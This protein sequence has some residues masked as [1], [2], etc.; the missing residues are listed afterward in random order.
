[1][2][3]KTKRMSNSIALLIAIVSCVCVGILFLVS[4]E[5]M[6]E[7]M[8][9][10]A[11]NNIMTSLNAKTQ[12]IDEYI[13]NAETTL[14]VFAKSGELIE[15]A[16]DPSNVSKQEAAQR[17]TNE[18][19]ATIDN[20]EGIYLASW[21]SQVITHPAPPVVG[22]VMREGDALKDL[23]DSMLNAPDKMYNTGIMASPASGELIISMYTPVYDGDTVV[24]YVGGAVLASGLKELLDASQIESLPNAEYSLI[25]IH[26]GVYIFDKDETL[27]NT[28]VKDSFLLDMMANAKNGIMTD[29]MEY[30][31]DGQGYF[32]VY[33]V[34]EDRE[35][36][37]VIRDTNSEIFSLV[38]SGRIALGILCLIAVMLIALLA[39]AVISMKTKPLTIAVD[40]IT[41]LK[42]LNLNENK[43]IKKYTGK[44]D[45]I[46]S[47]ANAVESLTHTLG[48]IVNTMGKCSESLTASADIMNKSSKELMERIETDA[49]TTQ[50]LSAG[51]I[52]TNEAISQV[53]TEIVNMQEL[54]NHIKQ[55]VKDGNVNSGK[56][57]ESSSE[58]T[59]AANTAAQNSTSKIAKTKIH[60]DEAV[61]NLQALNRINDM[62][63]QILEITTQTNLLSL[64]ASIEAARAGEAGRGFAVV[65]DEIAKLAN[66]SS[67]TVSQIQSLCEEANESIGQ[68]KDCF[69]DIVQFLETDVF[70]QFTEFANVSEQYSGVVADIK[71]SIDTI[72][73]STAAFIGSVETITEQVKSVGT[74]SSDNERGVEELIHNN[75]ETTQTV[76]EV[77]K[78]AEENTNNA[79]TLQ[80]IIDKFTQ[81]DSVK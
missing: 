19:F 22:K 63:A 59:H 43:S 50:E 6:T 38:Y 1:M 10:S 16:C 20:W 29:T 46:G 25:N 31:A 65:A 14:A 48:E 47:I 28:E 18:Y 62:A 78:A 66:S 37:L 13:K 70:K 76:D 75:N 9:E 45:E 81:D 79:Y 57:L 41:E 11:E 24:G 51:I 35:W 32:S 39:W 15:C 40:A 71:A 61:N 4:N 36:M 8:R 55:C 77:F 69:D 58:M 52:S 27:I 72:D 73:G 80:S 74:A 33:K 21:D 56:L 34:L 54:T 17:Y 3:Q 60:I 5:N 44:K 49:A 2:R 64:N 53:T 23:Q 12:V 7:T 68:V 30:S 42:N 26:T 67:E